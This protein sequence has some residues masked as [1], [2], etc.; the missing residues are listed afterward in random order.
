MKTFLGRCIYRSD[1]A[2]IYDNGLFRWLTLGSSVLQTLMYKR[3]PS[4]AG[5]YYI[6]PLIIAAKLI[7][8]DCCLLGLGG[9]GVIHALSPYNHL[10]MSV[11]YDEEI[12]TLAQRYFKIGQQKNLILLHEDAALFVKATSQQFG[13]ILV[14]IFDANHFPTSC[15]KA[16]FFSDCQEHLTPDG[17][18]AVNLANRHEQ[19]PVYDWIK[20]QF[21]GNTLTIPVKNCANVIIFAGR[22]NAIE[23]LIEKLTAERHLYRL[24]W[25]SQWGRIADLK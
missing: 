10:L 23:Q 20:H 8:A 17:I 9:G 25:D 4:R 5:L 18:L 21:Q 16:E 1:H 7:P 19:K 3:D 22:R 24:S 15:Y 14:D 11:E 6:K 12:I 2:T 13:H